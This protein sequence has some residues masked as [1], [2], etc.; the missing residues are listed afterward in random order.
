MPSHLIDVQSSKSGDTVKLVALDAEAR[1]KFT[2]LTY[3]SESGIVGYWEDNTLPED[4]NI[5]V[6]SL[7][8]TFQDA[9][10]VTRISGVQY[11]WI[12]SLCIPGNPR[13]WARDSEQAG[14][15]YANAY[16]TISAT[17]SENVTDGLLF[18]F[19]SNSL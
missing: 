19:P 18:P 5:R 6:A 2:A 1:Q 14:S 13:E 9:V 3:T 12:D 8:K 17:G 16:L 7:P 10:L 4:G 11:L 15:V